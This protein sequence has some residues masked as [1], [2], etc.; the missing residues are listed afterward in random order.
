[1]K[2]VRY[3]S[4]IIEHFDNYRNKYTQMISE[5]RQLSS[6]GVIRIT[7]QIHPPEFNQTSKS[8]CKPGIKLIAHILYCFSDQND[9][10]FDSIAGGGV[11]A[12]TGLF[13]VSNWKCCSFDMDDRPDKGPEI[14]PYFWDISGLTS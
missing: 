8:C 13:L 12:N 2:I 5:S 3:T 9:L 6:I 14:V 11:V 1:M 4:H 10:V 7:R